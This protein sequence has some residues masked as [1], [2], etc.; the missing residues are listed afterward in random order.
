MCPN[1]AA[2]GPPRTQLGRAAP[3]DIVIGIPTVSTRHAMLRVADTE[4]PAAGSVQVRSPCWQA[5]WDRLP[6]LCAACQCTAARW[7]LPCFGKSGAKTGAAGLAVP[8]LM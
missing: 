4:A 6:R 3:A 1:A 8:S 2:P 7:L 5:R